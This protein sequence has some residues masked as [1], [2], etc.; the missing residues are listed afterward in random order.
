[1]GCDIHVHY[2]IRTEQGAWKHY[3]WE[4]KHVVG[5]YEDGERKLS[6]DAYFKDPLHVDRNYNLFAVLADVR[7]GRGF[8]GVYTGEEFK[9]ISPP[10]G[11]PDDVSPEVR[12]ESDEWGVDGHSHSW[13][14]LAELLAFDYEQTRSSSGVVDLEEFKVFTEKG[15]PNEWSGDVIGRNVVHASNTEMLA[16]IK[17]G[18][19]N[20]GKM[21]VTRVTWR[22]TYRDAIGPWWFATLQKL[23]E[24]LCWETRGPESVRMVF[25]FDN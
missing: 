3:D 9:P 24:M 15:K 2:E 21:Y 25:W 16:Y 1:M 23:Q 13:L 22:E 17:D 14:T 4:A 12:N 7:N 10:R 6:Y 8:A 18:I 20:D 19:P 11:L 5:K